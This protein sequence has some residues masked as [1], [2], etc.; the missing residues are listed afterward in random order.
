[1]TLED[2]VRR[3]VG[4]RLFVLVGM[5]ACVEVFRNTH[6]LGARLNTTSAYPL[7]HSRCSKLTNFIE[8]FLVC[9]SVRIY[10]QILL[11]KVCIGPAVNPDKKRQWS[12]FSHFAASRSSECYQTTPTGVQAICDRRP[13]AIAVDSLDSFTMLNSLFQRLFLLRLGYVYDLL[14]L[15]LLFIIFPNLPVTMSGLPKYDC[16]FY[17]R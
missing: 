2:G 17:E 8:L 7:H 4:P 3:G 11:C 14:L 12:L 9:A 10:Y 16:Y 15:L 13:F 6:A 5:T 1:M